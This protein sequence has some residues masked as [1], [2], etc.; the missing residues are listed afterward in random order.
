M[1]IYGY[2]RLNSNRPKPKNFSLREQAKI[3]RNWSDEQGLEIKKIF[4]DN[5]A[6]SASLELPN[7]KKLISLIEQGKVSVLI[8][9]RLDRL[10]RKIRLH[11]Q[12]LK[13][14]EEHK[15]RFVSLAEDLDSKKKSGKKV[16]EAIGFLALWDARSIPDRT[17]EMIER[18]RKIGEQVG[19]APFGYTYQKKRLTP[20][21]KELSIATIIREKREDENLSYHKIAKYLNSQRLRAKRGGRWYA[22]TIKGIC[23]N[24]LYERF[25]GGIKARFLD[26][27]NVD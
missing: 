18:K 4:R 11:Q 25:T 3:I 14:F 10:T 23:E 9:A 19:H 1:S 17:R 22:E 6:N 21:T 24:P 12:L 5:E 7:L 26:K 27:A 13:L 16:L 8:V 15:I 20:L 2:I